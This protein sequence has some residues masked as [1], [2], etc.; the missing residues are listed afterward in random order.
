MKLGKARASGKADIS[1]L[2]VVALGFGAL[3]WLFFDSFTG[4]VVAGV[5]LWFIMGRN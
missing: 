5:V 4:G 1:L 2:V 3:G